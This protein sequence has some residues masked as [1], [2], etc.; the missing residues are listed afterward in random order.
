MEIIQWCIVR[1]EYIQKIFVKRSEHWVTL[2]YLSGGKINFF[3][4]SGE[5]S[6]PFSMLL[7]AG[8]FNSASLAQHKHTWSI[9]MS[10]LTIAIITPIILV[11]LAIRTLQRWSVTVD[12]KLTIR[13]IW[14]CRDGMHISTYNR[15]RVH[16]NLVIETRQC[17]TWRIS[18]RNQNYNLLLRDNTLY[19]Y[20]YSQTID[21]M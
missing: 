7:S 15:L 12:W 10:A 21:W 17:N 4:I 20:M 2:L 5:W 11:H 8:S 9:S 16:V 3:G 18:R 19:H 14:F 6:M 1:I 13:L